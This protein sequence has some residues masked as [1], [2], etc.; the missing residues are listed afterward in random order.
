[1]AAQEVWMVQE[2]TISFFKVMQGSVRTIKHSLQHDWST[3]KNVNWIPPIF[4]P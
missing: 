1:M 2:A 4:K 3:G